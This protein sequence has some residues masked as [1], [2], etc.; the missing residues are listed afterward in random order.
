MAWRNLLAVDPKNL[1]ADAELRRFFG[2]KV[3][4]NV[5]DPKDARSDCRLHPRR[6]PEEANIDLGHPQSY[7]TRS[8]SPNRTTHPQHP[9]LVWVCEKCLKTKSK[10]FS[11]AEDW[12]TPRATRGKSGSRLSIRQLGGRLKGNSR[13]QSDHMVSL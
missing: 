13:A 1:D 2:S 10:S 8:Q 12:K 6:T 3:V 7:G 4:S 5:K 11:S 9:F